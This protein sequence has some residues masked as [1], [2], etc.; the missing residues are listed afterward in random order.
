MAGAFVALSDDATA[1]VWNPAGVAKGPLGGVVFE[2][3]RGD[4]RRGT[5]AADQAARGRSYL[6]AVASPALGLAYVRTRVDAV[7]ADAGSDH[8][9]AHGEAGRLRV[10]SLAVRHLGVTLVQSLA[11]GLVVGTTLRWVRGRFA[12]DTR[13]EPIEPVARRLAEAAV[14]SGDTGSAFD[15]DVGVLATAGRLRL[16]ATWQ[17]LRE[18]ALEARDGSAWTFR[19]AVRAGV[20]VR[21]TRALTLAADADLRRRTVEGARDDRHVAVGGEWQAASWARVRA[22]G[23]RRMREPGAPVPALGGSVRVARRLWTDVFLS[24]SVKPQVTEWGVGARVEF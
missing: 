6:L 10:Q 16:G 7:S 20:A 2:G 9:E 11:E 18:A 5:P 17:N 15:V 4:L 1:V 23:R 14:L 3:A 8:G 13:V 22:G 12:T 21:V 19:R 24:R